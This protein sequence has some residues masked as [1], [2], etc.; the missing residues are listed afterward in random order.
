MARIRF[1]RQWT[2]D[3]PPGRGGRCPRA[4]GASGS[5]EPSP[6][7]PGES[8]G[9]PDRPGAGPTLLGPR[10]TSSRLC[11][12]RDPVGGGSRTTM[13]RTLRVGHEAQNHRPC[14][15]TPI[16]TDPRVSSLSPGGSV[17]APRTAA[18]QAGPGMTQPRC[19]AIS[20]TD[21][22]VQRIAGCTTSSA[23][24]RPAETPTPPRP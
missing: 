9:R 1:D 17:P 4:L 11:R 19:S 3:L 24:L 15:R 13:R 18:R 10:R 20:T 6:L 21:S 12:L 7:L 14:L 22:W 23:R 8:S 16:R 5:R 2:L